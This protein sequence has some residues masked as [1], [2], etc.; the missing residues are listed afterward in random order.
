MFPTKLFFAEILMKTMRSIALAVVLACMGSIA[1][2]QDR[3]GYDTDETADVQHIEGLNAS[4][5]QSSVA[6]CQASI[7]YEYICVRSYRQ[8]TTDLI[9]LLESRKKAVADKTVA[10]GDAI[11]ER[12][13]L[14]STASELPSAV[15]LDIDETV[16][17]NGPFQAELVLKSL[18]FKP[19]LWT[20]WCN[21]ADARCVPGAKEFIS[22]ARKAK[23]EVL[24]VSNRKNNVESATVA[25]LSNELGYV[26]S[27]C[28]V[29]LKDDIPDLDKERKEV[30][31]G[32]SVVFEPSSAQN[33]NYRYSWTERK[34]NKD[35]SK[36]QD[37]SPS[38]TNRR[39]AI[40]KKYTV[41]LIVG[42]KAEDFMSLEENLTAAE[43]KTAFREKMDRYLDRWVLLPNPIY[44]G[45]WENAV[46]QGMSKPE[47]LRPRV[48]DPFLETPPSPEELLPAIPE[49]FPSLR[50]APSDDD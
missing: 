18:D 3:A 35:S 1:R 32:A 13:L 40:S 27:P 5:K 28:D 29:Y 39:I 16:L 34:E 8:A 2:A 14:E 44:G 20:E 50:A 11:S 26:V 37:F 48:V 22:A 10:I 12:E 24:F 42:D 36:E 25:N 15:I 9:Q 33:V 43:R 21:R 49:K 46:L 23:C 17:D 47:G 6:W 38:K 7:E 30:E 45:N 41:E 19:K 31:K 4:R